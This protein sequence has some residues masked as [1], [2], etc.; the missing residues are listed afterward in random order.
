MLAFLQH[1]SF[2]NP[3]LVEDDR[4]LMLGFKAVI[5]QI[6]NLINLSKFCTPPIDKIQDY[7]LFHFY[8]S[9]IT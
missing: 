9:L 2:S 7:F 8:Y 5:I 1:Y 6:L 3:G 4:V